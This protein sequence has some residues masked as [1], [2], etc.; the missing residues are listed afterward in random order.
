MADAYL[1]GGDPRNVLAS[2]LL[3][4][5]TGLPPLLIHVG[6]DEVLLDDARQ[7][8]ARAREDHVQ[9]TLEIWQGMI[10][11][12]H[13]FGAMLPEA[14]EAIAKIVGFVKSHWR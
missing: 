5:L 8:H 2:P 6:S 3:G 12:W 9:S 14:N 11:V 10:H 4:D 13:M 1:A 7:L